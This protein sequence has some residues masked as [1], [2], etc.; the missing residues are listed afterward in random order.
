M[1][2]VCSCC[3]QV[4]KFSDALR[5]ALRMED[6]E[7][8]AETFVKCEAAGAPLGGREGLAGGVG[9]QPGALHL[10]PPKRPAWLKRANLCKQEHCVSRACMLLAGAEE[11][12]AVCQAAA[13][14]A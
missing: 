11:G 9:G 5:M 13:A 4:G 8:A 12:V 2:V 14:A 7:L 6:H 10:C 3:V 1:H